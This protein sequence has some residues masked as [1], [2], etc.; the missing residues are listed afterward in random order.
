[1]KSYFSRHLQVIFA[2]FGTL[3]RSPIASLMTIATIAITL[4]LPTLLYLAVK[5][6]QQ[7]NEGW[8]GHPQISIFIDAEL[9]I[10]EARLIFEELRLHP[11]IAQ[12]EFLSPEQA[13]EEFSELGGVGIELDFLGF[14]PLPASIV[15][16]PD[17]AN[18]E[19][20]SLN[21]LK[22]ELERIEG[23]ESIRLDLEWT[24]R[25]NSILSGV[26]KLTLLLFG[27]LSL[28]LI[29]L[30][31]NTIQLLIMNRREEIEII[32]LVGGSNTFV[33]R[34]FLYYGLFFGILGGFAALMLLAAIAIYIAPNLRELS[35]A[36]QVKTLIYTP[37]WL[38]LA[39]IVFAGGALGWLAARI[40]VARHLRHIKPR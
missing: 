27:L 20:A 26:S 16:M 13:L 25:F 3:A 17:K 38:E 1:M 34:P 31:G 28:S 22:I 37:N 19:S 35:A 24:D 29:I 15:A 5:T 10:Q 39:S 18:S 32:K 9:D 30:V 14:N 11:A 2:T 12:A 33:R 36:Y 23:I 21:E 8:Q 7:L 40:S 4:I 6:G